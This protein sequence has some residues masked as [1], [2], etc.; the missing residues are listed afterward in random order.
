MG[1]FFESGIPNK[2]VTAEFRG[3]SFKVFVMLPAINCGEGEINKLSEVMLQVHQAQR[4][5]QSSIFLDYLQNPQWPQK[6]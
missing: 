1:S 4:L 6:A 2:S 5:G 3:S